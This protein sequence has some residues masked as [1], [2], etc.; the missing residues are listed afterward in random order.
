MW[1]DPVWFNLPIYRNLLFT[2]NG[3]SSKQMKRIKQMQIR[4]MQIIYMI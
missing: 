4:S 3:L 2:E 1:T